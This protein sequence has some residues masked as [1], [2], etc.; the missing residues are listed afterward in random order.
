MAPLV[1][2]LQDLATMAEQGMAPLVVAADWSVH[3]HQSFRDSCVLIVATFP[4]EP[5]VKAF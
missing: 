1:V 3:L 4:S 2:E 5:F